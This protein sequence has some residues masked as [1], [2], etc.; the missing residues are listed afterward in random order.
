MYPKALLK[1]RSWSREFDK[2]RNKQS[3]TYRDFVVKA[4][5]PKLAQRHRIQIEVKFSRCS[6]LW[7]IPYTRNEFS[8]DAFDRNAFDRPT[9][10]K[11]V[12]DL[13]KKHVVAIGETA[14]AASPVLG[15][16]GVMGLRG[17]SVEES[18]G[19]DG[20]GKGGK[21][22]YSGPRPSALRMQSTM[23]L[24]FAAQSWSRSEA[25]T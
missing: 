22:T 8:R 2:D 5:A 17:L 4:I 7:R 10:V 3:C 14:A 19:G 15:L 18:E 9:I 25:H 21:R 11:S 1:E 12:S 23:P 13:L 6:A 24:S 20:G 16:D